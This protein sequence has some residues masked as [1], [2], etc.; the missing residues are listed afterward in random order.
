M[1]HL[2]S[3]ELKGYRLF[4]EYTRLAEAIKE[5]SGVW[6]HIRESKWLVE[7]DFSTKAVHDRIAPLTTVGDIVLVQRVYRD[8]TASGL[9]QEQVDW[10]NGRSFQSFTETIAS[11][12]PP[13][14]KAAFAGLGAL[15][16][17]PGLA[18]LGAPPAPAPLPILPPPFGSALKRW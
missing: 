6:C 13:P 17:K 1:V 15:G 14:M 7:T 4:F 5:I 3:Y 16:L 8:W 12:C 10:L 11:L 2:V 9:T 18:S